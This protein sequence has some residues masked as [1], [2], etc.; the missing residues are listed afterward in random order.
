MVIFLKSVLHANIEHDCWAGSG[1]WNQDQP[2]ILVS[3]FPHPHRHRHHLNSP[4][5]NSSTSGAPPLS[6][7]MWARWW[8]GKRNQRGDPR[9]GRPKQCVFFPSF[10]N[11]TDH[12]STQ[13]LRRFPLSST[14]PR[15]LT[16]TPHSSNEPKPAPRPSK[17]SGEPKLEVSDDAKVSTTR[18]CHVEQHGQ[19]K[20]KACMWNDTRV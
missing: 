1:V 10:L 14:H 20:P 3:F 19:K 8:R 17:T 9:N 4:S 12:L 18:R 15:Q 6:R 7:G 13:R 11:L 2:L 5:Q 16:T